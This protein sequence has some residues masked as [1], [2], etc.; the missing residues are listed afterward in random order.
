M[1]YFE[2]ELALRAARIRQLEQQNAA[3]KQQQA[4]LVAALENIRD[5]ANEDPKDYPSFSYAIRIRAN[6]A[7][8][9][10]GESE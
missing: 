3:L 5:M 10:V 9:A 8:A 2:T 6:A 7:L 4:D 1:T